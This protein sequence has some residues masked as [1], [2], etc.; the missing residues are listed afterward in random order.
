MWEI[1]R[2]YSNSE[3]PEREGESDAARD[4]TFELSFHARGIQR[5]H[6]RMAG[7]KECLASLAQRRDAC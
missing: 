5:K 4:R 6:S 2:Y 3:L 7:D 1:K